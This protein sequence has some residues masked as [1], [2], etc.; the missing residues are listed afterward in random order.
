MKEKGEREIC[1]PMFC[2]GSISVSS[3]FHSIVLLDAK[4]GKSSLK[5]K[6]LYSI[7]LGRETGKRVEYFSI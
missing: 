5:K 2:K 1:N 7:S 3:L 4:N 6:S